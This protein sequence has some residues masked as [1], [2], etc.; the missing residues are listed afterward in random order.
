MTTFVFI[1]HILK[2]KHNMKK[3]LLTIINHVMFKIHKTV[4]N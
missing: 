1:G 2:M 4:Q 3:Y